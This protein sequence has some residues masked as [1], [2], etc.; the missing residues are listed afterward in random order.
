MF[1]CRELLLRPS[2]YGTFYVLALHPP[3]R[4]VVLWQFNKLHHVATFSR[5]RAAVLAMPRE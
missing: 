4:L 5:C 3:A 1:F 2:K